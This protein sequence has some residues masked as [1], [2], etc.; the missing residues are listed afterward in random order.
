MHVMEMLGLPRALLADRV[1]TA[2]EVGL[3]FCG[4]QPKPAACCAQPTCVRG[5]GWEHM[6]PCM[7]TSPLRLRQ[8][9]CQQ[10]GAPK[11]WAR[12]KQPV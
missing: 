9:Q 8:E 5:Q 4:S 1:G 6:A 12:E 3:L 10:V 11:T 2:A 7:A